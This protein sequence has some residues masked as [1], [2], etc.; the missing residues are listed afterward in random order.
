MP[1]N[2][3]TNGFALEEY[4]LGGGLNYSPAGIVGCDVVAPCIIAATGMERSDPTIDLEK[5]STDLEIIEKDT[6]HFLVYNDEIRWMRKKFVYDELRNKPE[7]N[8]KS[9]L[10]NFYGSTITNYSKFAQVEDKILNKEYSVANTINNGIAAV[11]LLENNQQT[12]NALILKP[13]L[14]KA[15]VYTST[16]KK[17]IN[18]IAIQCPFSGGYAVYQARNM[19]MSVTNSVIEFTDNC[20]QKPN[21]SI[22]TMLSTKGIVEVNR[23][24]NLY[25]NPN[26]GNMLLDY[27]LKQDEVGTIKIY[28]IAGKLIVNYPLNANANQLQINNTDLDNGIYMYDI[29]VNDKTVKTEKLVIIKQ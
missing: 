10:Q 1:S 13:L 4:F 2:N 26:S 9:S 20:D 7:L 17:V 15:Y 22:E 8:T 6:T 21:R 28:D 23:S 16:D 25:P 27:V 12:I 14:N 5:Y 29:I 3:K 18:G 24:F 11:N 19:I